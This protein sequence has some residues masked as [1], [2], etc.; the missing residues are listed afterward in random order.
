MN[1]VPPI[2]PVLK[3]EVFKY[4][5]YVYVESFEEDRD[6]YLFI[7]QGHLGHRPFPKTV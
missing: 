2:I 5:L 4:S 3:A 1:G 6:R 7:C